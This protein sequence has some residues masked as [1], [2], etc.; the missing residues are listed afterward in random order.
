MEIVLPATTTA[1]TLEIG[2]TGLETFGGVKIEVTPSDTM[3]D[4][5][6]A[7]G[8]SPTRLVV[9]PTVLI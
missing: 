1:A 6:G 9:P 7:F 8:G 4:T 5:I 3:V 2:M